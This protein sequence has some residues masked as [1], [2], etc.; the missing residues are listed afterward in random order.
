MRLLLATDGSDA[1]IAARQLILA[2][3]PAGIES[4]CVLSVVAP[5]TTWLSPY[6]ESFYAGPQALDRI[7]EEEAA[8]ARRI[9]EQEA[10]ALRSAGLSAAV[11]THTG[12]VAA[13]IVAT[14]RRRGVDLIV[15]GHRGLGGLQEIFIGSTALHVV[16][17]ADR[18]V[19]VARAPEHALRRVV[20]AT[21]GSANAAKALEFATRLPL[22]AAS[23]FV[24][25]TV[26]KPHRPF[27]GLFPGD[28][29]ARDATLGEIEQA[30]RRAGEALVAE[31]AAALETTRPIHRHVREGDPTTEILAVAEQEAAD[32][33]VVGAHGI[34]GLR[35][36]F[37][38]S[39][40]DRVL[41]RAS[42]SVCIVR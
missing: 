3:D 2:L 9:V 33:I 36:W 5:P 25:V 1:A 40:A 34:S 20:L 26:V 24:V 42:R 37:V 41:R 4:V 11:E 17:T 35:G 39:V 29:G 21:D 13:T 12:D 7:F 32:L 22:P 10:A 30:Q 18:P 15:L 28:R 14:A 23:E 38:G 31:A 19:L 16:H 8:A 6:V 27:L